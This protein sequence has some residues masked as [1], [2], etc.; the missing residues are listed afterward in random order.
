MLARFSGMTFHG[1]ECA[2]TSTPFL[3]GSVRRFF[4]V[5]NRLDVAL[6]GAAELRGIAGLRTVEA[7][8]KA[9]VERFA[10]NLLLFF[11]SCE[12]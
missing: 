12:W 1:L 3:A 10:G 5:G 7:V 9:P 2:S 8:P 4:A 11:A 6:L